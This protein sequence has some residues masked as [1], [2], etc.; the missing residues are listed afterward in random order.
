MTDL[1][2]PDLGDL[3]L[4]LV[5]IIGS[6]RVTRL[7]VADS[8]PPSAHLRAW[9]EGHTSGGWE[10]L[11]FCPFCLSFWIVLANAATGWGAHALGDP[12]FTAWVAG[13][14]IF[15]ASYLAAIF[16]HFDEGGA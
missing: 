9:W 13:N 1:L 3:L 14:A 10:E 12:W 6:A 16:V 8:F 4:A 11:L 5:F 2:N 7:I 15:A